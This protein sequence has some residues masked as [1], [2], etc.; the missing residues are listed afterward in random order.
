MLN[1]VVVEAA[2]GNLQ[3]SAERP[4]QVGMRVPAEDDD[5]V[6]AKR[7]IIQDGGPFRDRAAGC[8]RWRQTF[9]RRR[10]AANGR[11]L[12]FPAVCALLEE[13]GKGAVV[14]QI[15]RLD[16]PFWPGAASG[17]P[18]LALPRSTRLLEASCEPQVDR[19]RRQPESLNRST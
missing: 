9:W 8:K 17:A 18:V 14:E 4:G 15:L 5:S 19:T 12:I 13:S 7:G 3:A 16:G 1:V 2:E 11:D 10:R 6:H